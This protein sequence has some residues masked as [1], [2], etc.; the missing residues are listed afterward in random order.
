[1]T[2]DVDLLRELMNMAR[3]G[4]M[5]VVKQDGDTM[6]VFFAQFPG[7]G[8]DG[9]API[10]VFFCPWHNEREKAATVEV[11]GEQFKQQGVVRYVFVCT[12]WVAAYSEKE[13][14]DALKGKRPDVM[15]CDR[16]DREEVLIIT[17]VEPGRPP[18][19]ETRKLTRRSEKD[20]DIGEPEPPKTGIQ[21]QGGRMLELLGPVAREQ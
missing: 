13:W 8:S 12:A 11:L 5:N 19:H 18:L 6:P 3:E 10:G 17:G 20:V 4:A 15:P 2:E 9:K 1:M 21:I 14:P 7:K 16:P